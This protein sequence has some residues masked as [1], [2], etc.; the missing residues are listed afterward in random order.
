MRAVQVIL[1]IAREKTQTT[2]TRRLPIVKA[3]AKWTNNQPFLR[4]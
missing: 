2:M 3:D 4:K 1:N